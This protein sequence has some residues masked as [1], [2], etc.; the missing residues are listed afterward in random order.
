MNDAKAQWAS[1]LITAV[2]GD[3]ADFFGLAKGQLGLL[4]DPPAHRAGADKTLA[5]LE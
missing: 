4:D 2:G 5:A 3:L 1:Q